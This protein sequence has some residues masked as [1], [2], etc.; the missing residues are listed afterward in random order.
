MKRIRVLCNSNTTTK[1]A[2]EG[3]Q[4]KLGKKYY[5]AADYQNPPCGSIGGLLGR[6]RKDKYAKYISPQQTRQA[7][8]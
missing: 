8:S 6:K 7:V 2:M 5:T 4:L 3:Q 1:K